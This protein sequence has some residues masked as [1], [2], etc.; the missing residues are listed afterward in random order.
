MNCM[1]CKSSLMVES[2]SFGGQIFFCP[3]CQVIR[4]K[5]KRNRESFLSGRLSTRNIY[6][7]P[8]LIEIS[9]ELA[10]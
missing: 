1:I 4:G 2:D 6:N 3:H 8:D 9:E 10:R 5:S 7:W